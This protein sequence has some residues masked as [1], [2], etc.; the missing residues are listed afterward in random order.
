MGE[1]RQSGA[2]LA[3]LVT[4]PQLGNLSLDRLEHLPARNQ[5]LLRIIQRTTP[6]NHLTP[7]LPAMRPRKIPLSA[8]PASPRFFIRGTYI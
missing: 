2:A 7:Y 8:A 4:A 6:W 1:P 5:A 3:L